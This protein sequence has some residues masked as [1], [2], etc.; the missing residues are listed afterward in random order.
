MRYSKMMVIMLGLAMSLSTAVGFRQD[1]AM[2]SAP[3]SYPM[4]Q[5]APPQGQAGKSLAEF[6]AAQ[7]ITGTTQTL[8]N[9][10]ILASGSD[11]NVVLAEQGADVTLDTVNLI[12][13]GDMTSGDGSNFNGQNAVF[14][15][16][17]SKA[18][19]RNATLRPQ[20]FPN[21]PPP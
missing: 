9:K 2:P 20:K 12:K 17:Q 10:S 5:G 6:T 16:S 7:R 8:S 21:L 3:P 1:V 19:L 13:T 18:L 15:A 14:L 11:Q 4:P